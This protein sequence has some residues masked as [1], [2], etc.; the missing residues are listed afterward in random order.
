MTPQETQ[1][2]RDL[3]ARIDRALLEGDFDRCLMDVC[4]DCSAV[5]AD[6][7]SSRVTAGEFRLVT[8][9]TSMPRGVL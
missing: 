7:G 6:P 8:L 3:K 4:T 5:L 1:I 9:A 2:L